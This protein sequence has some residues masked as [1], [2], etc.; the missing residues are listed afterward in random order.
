MVGADV[1]KLAQEIYVTMAITVSTEVITAQLLAEVAVLYAAEKYKKSLWDWQFCPRFGR[2]ALCIVARDGDHIV[3]FN[4][5]MPIKINA[6]SNQVMDAIW[7][8]DFIVAPAYRGK[9]VGQSIK[10]EMAKVFKIPIMSLGISDSA[11]PLLLKKGWSSPTRVDAWDLLKTPKTFKQLVLFSW[12]KV[13]R[14]YLSL[15]T[16]HVQQKYFAK[17]LD[18]LPQET[19]VQHLWKIHRAQS[20]EIEVVRNY[21]YLK[22]R[23]A[24]CPFKV[25][26]FLHVGSATK[27]AQA[28]VVFRLTPG[29]SLIVVDFIGSKNTEVVS[30]VCSFLLQCYASV[31]AI[32]WNTS[33][34]ALHSGLIANGFVKKNYGS[35]FATLSDDVAG[36]WGL[37]AGD[38]DGDFLRVAKEQSSISTVVVDVFSE[39]SVVS[40]TG[41]FPIV[42]LPG[43]PV[44]YCPEGFVY[45][46]ITEQEF[47]SMEFAWCKLMGRA[48]ANPLFMSWQWM[49][50]W[51][52]Q[53][54][55]H[56]KLNLSVF[57]IYEKDSL[58]GILPLYKY[59]KTLL[60]NYQF[61]GNA[62][63]IFPTVRSEY[64]SPIFDLQKVDV[65]YQSL[66]AYISSHPCNT[67]FIFPDT[68]TNKMPRLNYWQHRMD[69]G[70]RNPVSGSFE[71]YLSTLG[72]MTRL[73]AFNRR[74]YLEE[75]YSN[76]EFTLLKPESTQL[77][78]FFTHLNSF[79]LLRWGKPCFEPRAV[80]FHKQLLQGPM[81][82][83]TFLSYL[84]VDGL[85]VSAS[86]NVQVD[87]VIYNIQSGYL[88]DF[89][90]KISLGTLHMGWLIEAAFKDITV[91]Y[92]DFL[93]GFGRAEDYK[94]HYR[95]D[96]TQFYT[97][98][99]FSSS[100]IGTLY[101]SRFWLK[102]RTKKMMNFISRFIREPT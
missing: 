75:Y 73:K 92:F 41:A 96:V 24:D 16:R 94:K 15:T 58:I 43:K 97:L 23:Y 32:H 55:N 82:K 72:R 70:Y 56:L 18:R 78:D 8:C 34:S 42:G 4:A 76:V 69:F 54:S 100:L 36:S 20:N 52:R 63:G 31:S 26:R 17:E 21:D 7:S 99:Y 85:V 91:N 80:E 50:G 38:S 64:I 46:Q 3:G 67:S 12:S 81:G 95:G 37:V 57:L 93:A 62:W 101:C 29:N 51:W 6:E 65:L 84:I 61:I 27:G 14:V 66:Q 39:N 87:D 45:R 48:D 30:A 10:D 98:Q 35:R 71:Q 25:Y 74:N 2:E 102:L 9:G 77:D 47:Y 90:K 83:S 86:Y 79:H 28:L 49:V 88:E 11:F 5:T 89:D 33:F 60:E 19:V 40:P 44:Y 13:C 1:P 22:W 59:K 53:W 68:P